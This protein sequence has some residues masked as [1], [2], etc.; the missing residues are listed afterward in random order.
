MA[1]SSLWTEGHQGSAHAHSFI[2]LCYGCAD[3]EL[4]KPEL[5]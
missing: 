2:P 3:L 1:R 4:G 5:G